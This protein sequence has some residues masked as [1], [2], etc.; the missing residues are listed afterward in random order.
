MR[1]KYWTKL[2]KN[3]YGG[4]LENFFDI[5]L[6]SKKTIENFCQNPKKYLN[7][8]WEKNP[9]ELSGLLFVWRRQSCWIK[10]FWI[11]VNQI[12]LSFFCREQIFEIWRVKK[13]K[14]FFPLE[15]TIHKHIL[16]FCKNFSHKDYIQNDPSSILTFWKICLLK[17]SNSVKDNMLSDTIIF[18]AESFCKS[19]WD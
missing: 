12:S 3:W 5:N 14:R 18:F 1:R 8:F 15:K 7:S 2:M 16:Y 19:S 11:E 9:P 4:P 17:F 6:L 10:F 13:M